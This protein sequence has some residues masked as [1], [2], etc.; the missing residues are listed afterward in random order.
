MSYMY[1]VPNYIFV[2]LSLYLLFFCFLLIYFT[3]R[4][5][6]GNINDVQ[7]VLYRYCLY[8]SPFLI[9]IIYSEKIK[10]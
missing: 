2:K 8:N 7:S 5:K 6:N 10:F 1:M 3:C 4:D 9:Y